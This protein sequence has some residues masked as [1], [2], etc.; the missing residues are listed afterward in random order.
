M[1]SGSRVKVNADSKLHHTIHA[2]SSTAHEALSSAI[3]VQQIDI[4]VSLQYSDQLY[5]EN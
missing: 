5:Y 3:I 1:K 2:T 4:L